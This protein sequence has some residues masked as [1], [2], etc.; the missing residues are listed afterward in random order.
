MKKPV[1][2][3]WD[4]RGAETKSFTHCFHSYPAM[5]IPQVAARLLDKYGPKARLVLD[6]F[7]GTGTSLV[8]ANLRG[9]SAVGVDLNPLA[10][11]IAEAK[12]TVINLQKL[13]LYLKN[14]NDFLFAE[15]FSA[16]AQADPPQFPNIDF[17]FDQ[18]IQRELAVIKK[19]LGGI[20]DGD[21]RNFFKVAFSTV[22]RESSWT[23]NGEF[24]LYR[25][26]E[27]QRGRFQPDVFGSMEAKLARNRK[28]LQEFA[29]H[30]RRSQTTVRR[31]SSA[32]T[33]FA[34][35]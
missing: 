4:F 8:E 15:R 33:T 13:D 5:M 21:V 1:D 29:A 10:C 9:I 31:T 19:Y 20:E 30:K 6:P 28:G 32:E 26:T 11:L 7:C 18:K 35:T 34:E 12:T 2:Q 24:K 27:E 17:W 25:M 14:F 16:A 22:V 23:R 3:T